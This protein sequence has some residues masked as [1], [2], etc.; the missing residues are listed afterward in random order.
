LFEALKAW[1]REAAGGK[2][3]FT[4]AH[5]TTLVEITHAKPT[6]VKALLTI[7]GVGPPLSTGTAHACWQS[8]PNTSNHHRHALPLLARL[9]QQLQ[10]PCTL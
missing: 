4:M 2:P 7:K 5:N 8:S 10:S 3:A 1:R 6:T 9:P